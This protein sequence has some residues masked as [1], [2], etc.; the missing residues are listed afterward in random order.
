MVSART[1]RGAATAT[2]HSTP[3]AMGAGNG[4]RELKT[5]NT[6][7]HHPTS[8]AAR[9]LANLLVAGAGVLIRAGVHAYRQA[10]VSECCCLC[11]LF[12]G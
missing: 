4:R 2:C 10:I 9:V 8:Q 12:F 5:P 3:A 7:P 1:T 11:G 6:H